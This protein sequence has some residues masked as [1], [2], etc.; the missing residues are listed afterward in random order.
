LPRLVRIRAVKGRSKTDWIA[1]GDATFR[2][3]REVERI[4][5][6][7]LE[8]WRRLGADENESRGLIVSF[9]NDETVQKVWIPVT[10]LHG[11][12][13]HSE[14]SPV[15][16]DDFV[17]EQE[18]AGEV[19]LVEVSDGIVALHFTEILSNCTRLDAVQGGVPQSFKEWWNTH[20][21]SSEKS[22]TGRA[23]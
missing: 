7:K 5:R 4:I 13:S 16:A 15:H 22:R 8:L 6:M 9:L 11:L 17:G 18:D 21:K 1:A 3:A 19:L 20:A 23:A 14:S 10:G 2:M 12:T